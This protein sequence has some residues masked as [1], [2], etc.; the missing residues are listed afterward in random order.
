[1]NSWV[2]A[3]LSPRDIAP[4]VNFKQESI[5]YPAAL[6]LV[7][8]GRYWEYE[9]YRERDDR[10]PD[11]LNGEVFENE[12][13]ESKFIRFT[14]ISLLVA[15]QEEGVRQLEAMSRRRDLDAE[16]RAA[17]ALMASLGFADMGINDKSV[18]VCADLY[19]EDLK[20]P[21][22]AKIAIALQVSLRHGEGGDYRKAEQWCSKARR[23]LDNPGDAVYPLFPLRRDHPSAPS[24][25][26]AK[27]WEGMEVSVADNQSMIEFYAFGKINFRQR[28]TQPSSQYWLEKDDHA[29]I[30]A[31]LYLKESFERYVRDP[32]MR[33][34]P[35]VISNEDRISRLLHAYWVECQ[36][37]GHWSF[38]RQASEL[39]GRERLLRPGEGADLR[40]WYRRE[41]LARLRNSGSTDAFQQAVRSIREEGPLAALRAELDDATRRLENQISRNDL[42]ILQEAA[43]LL[44]GHQADA[45][46]E[47]LLTSEA[48][49]Y[50]S[51]GPRGASADALWNTIG[52]L[53]Q[54]VSSGNFLVRSIRERHRVRGS[55]V[56]MGML[57]VLHKVDWKTVSKKE[58]ERWVHLIR[59]TED[60]GNDELLE[61]GLY[62]MML[63]GQRDCYEI[64]GSRIRS[65]GLTLGDAATL[66]DCYQAGHRS[67]LLKHASEIIAVCREQVQRTRDEAARSSYGYGGINACLVGVL[68]S[69]V[70]ADTGAEMWNDVTQFLLDPN[71]AFEEK[72]PVLDWLANR[73]DQVPDPVMS[74]V[75]SRSEKLRPGNTGMRFFGE[76]ASAA[77][78]RFLCSAKAMSQM[79][80]ISEFVSLS[81]SSEAFQRIEAAKSAKF[82]GRVADPAIVVGCLLQMTANEEVVV[83]AEAAQGLT[84]FLTV[85][86]DLGGLAAQRLT[87][88]L[89]ND[90]FSVPFAVLRGLDSVRSHGVLKLPETLRGRLNWV[91]DTHAVPRL[92]SKASE[93]VEISESPD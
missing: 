87:D 54:E 57:R 62:K 35:R 69:S 17:A 65:N 49:P 68:T 85:N 56:E 86:S 18:E 71:V 43:P 41:G 24:D 88:L 39:L 29:G 79:D 1:M 15:G 89:D 7:V 47:S 8:S 44:T 51:A 14:G 60:S 76:D 73:I 59:E 53:A 12:N 26:I 3:L 55:V 31:R 45:V 77:W 42:I 27:V 72:S 38:A 10:L 75:L 93:L 4:H 2:M 48:P 82:V 50:T 67:L 21:E 30:A 19:S 28:F 37:A 23:H 5:T 11:L 74:S 9:N 78:L 83:R 81:N 13:I 80:A 61:A 66:V 58:T 90:G 70:S 16:M 34:R 52:R 22:L 64:L 6:A 25:V 91:A 36:L 84:K 40:D 46:C 33:V 32:S 63:L 20:L 92:R